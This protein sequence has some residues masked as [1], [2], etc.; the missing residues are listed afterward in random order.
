MTKSGLSVIL[1]ILFWV[2]IGCSTTPHKHSKSPETVPY[3]PPPS[4]QSPTSPKKVGILLGPGGFKTFAHVGL[5]K[6][7]V[8]ARVPIQAVVGLEW[9]ALP[10]A[11]FAQNG[12]V[13]EVE[14]KLYKLEQTEVPSRGFFSD[15]IK[16]ASIKTLEGFLT[17]NLSNR[18][19]GSAAVKFSCPSLS[20]LSGVVIW[21]DRGQ[22]S[23][24]LQRCLSYPPLYK[25]RGP[26][27]AASFAVRE[28][29]AKLRSMGAE[30][31]VFAN[32]LG[33]GELLDPAQLL[34]DYPSATLWQE[35]KRSL[36]SQKHE[37]DEVVDIDTRE[38][39]INDFKQR[40]EL[41]ERGSLAGRKFAEELA[42]KYG[43]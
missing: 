1:S 20:L 14:W 15:T 25:P 33:P 37:A 13:H 30:L 35:L 42:K 2:T 19:I 38:F 43:Y 21:Q 39:K 22:F 40:K 10:A 17:A 9:G 31:I 12:Q 4:Q 7:L 23:D 41:V 28:A 6:E 18:N 16:P 24:S 26:W 27:T 36:E 3:T 34:S 11:L 32:V 8:K 29:I 5:L